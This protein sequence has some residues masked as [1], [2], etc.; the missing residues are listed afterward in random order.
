MNPYKRRVVY[1]FPHAGGSAGTYRS[2]AGLAKSDGNILLQPVELPGR[3]TRARETQIHQLD[4]LAKYLAD[5]I[6]TDFRQQQQKGISE[7]ATFGH[8]FGGV[9]SVIV[10]QKLKELYGLVPEFSVVSCSIAPSIQVDDGLHSLSDEQLLEQMREDQG[11][12]AAVLNEPILARRMVA[13]LRNDYQIRF[14]FK[15][16]E[17][18]LVEQPLTL[19]SAKEDPHVNREDMSAWESYTTGEASHITIDGG[20]F[21]VYENWDVVKEALERESADNDWALAKTGME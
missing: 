15:Q 19:L 12:P 20:H 9:M 7:W 4:E 8:S 3:G 5:F 16:M 17:N 6:C 10:S 21:A 18:L 1:A 14:Q 11:T 2:W 13:Q